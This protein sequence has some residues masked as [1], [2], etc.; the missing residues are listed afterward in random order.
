MGRNFDEAEASGMASAMGANATDDDI[1]NVADKMDSMNRG[2]LAAVWD[3]VVKLWEAFKSP[4]TPAYVKTIIIGGLIYMVSP[5]DLIPDFIPI[6]GLVDD[7]GVI[8]LVFNQFIRLCTADD[9][10]VVTEMVVQGTLTLKELRQKIKVLYNRD[11]V[12]QSAAQRGIDLKNTSARITELL[13]TGDYS[14]AR[15]YLSDDDKKPIHEFKIR[16]DEVS[17]EI[18]EGLEITA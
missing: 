2:P 18:Y 6:A 11:D 4:S 16:A 8:G 1:Q 5:I 14:Y 15:G 3:K 9:P 12:K 10:V 7:V 17:D 13:K